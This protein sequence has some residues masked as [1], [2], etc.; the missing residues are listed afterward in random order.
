MKRFLIVSIS[1]M[2]GNNTGITGKLLDTLRDID[3]SKYEVNLFDTSFF[4][5]KHNPDNYPVAHY[6]SLPVYLIEKYIRKIPGVRSEYANWLIV[7]QFK[8]ILKENH[9]DL[10]V[11]YHTPVTSDSLI[12]IAH[13]HGTKVLM[14]PWGGEIMCASRNEQR[15]L[16]SAFTN[17]DYV[18]GYENS[19]CILTAKNTFKVQDSKIRYRKQ[20]QKGV[21]LLQQMKGNISRS[22]MH[23]ILNIPYSD[24]NIVCAYNGYPTHRHE[25]IIQ[26]IIK[27]KGV[28]PHNYQLVFPMTYGANEEY[29]TAMKQLCD[30]NG[31]R[32]CFIT[33]FITNEQ[34]A[35]LHLITDLFINI[36]DT[37][38]GNAFMIEA[39][40][41]QNQIITGRWLGYKQFEQF[42]IPYHLIDKPEDLSEKLKLIFSD[43]IELPVV[44]DKL[45]EMYRIPDGYKAESYWTKLIDSI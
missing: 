12:K 34:M 22:E 1:P 21:V 45:I 30:N 20:Y 7:K 9:F 3:K 17:V 15:I 39:L 13:K 29:A 44:P 37:D 24:Y 26:S 16:Q 27:N 41:A 25:S 23:Q 42:G 8:S 40:F 19:N 38:C 10:V 5:K 43:K 32:N 31:L 4:D 28:L 6:Y 2:R 35:C 14:Y 36:Q 18:G 11:L 33:A